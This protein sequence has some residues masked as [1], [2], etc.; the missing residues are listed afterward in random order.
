VSEDGLR[1]EMQHWQARTD[2]MQVALDHMREDRD[3]L[4]VQIETLS[5][6][7]AKALQELAMYK[8]MVDRMR[9]AM[10]QGAEL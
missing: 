6:V 2:D 4:K 3:L 10:S 1:A 8:Q 7:H 9:I 5:E